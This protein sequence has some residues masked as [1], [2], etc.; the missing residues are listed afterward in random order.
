MIKKSIVLMLMGL[1]FLIACSDKPNVAPTA[2]FNLYIQDGMADYDSVYLIIDSVYTNTSISS[3][4]QFS[5]PDTIEITQYRNGNQYLLFQREL[6]TGEITG[7]DI[8]FGGG[9]VFIDDSTYSLIPLDGGDFRAQASYLFALTAGSQVN[10]LVDINLFQSL[11]P[12]DQFFYYLNPSISLINI[13]SS[14]AISGR[15][16]PKANIY[17]FEQ[18]SQDTLSFTISEGDALEF[19]FYGLEPGLYDLLCEPIGDDTLSYESLFN[20]NISVISGDN[21]NIG[22]LTLPEP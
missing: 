6:P 7:V 3:I 19:G 18:D 16:S 15:T 1:V 21:Y 13:D 12:G 14:G 4:A 2:Q 20:E 10:A 8:L 22:L 9:A 11:S 17:L 5:G